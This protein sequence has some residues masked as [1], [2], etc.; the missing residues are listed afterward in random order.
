MNNEIL[1]NQYSMIIIKNIK[2]E[3]YEF[4]PITI[5]CKS[6]SKLLDVSIKLT[7]NGLKLDVSYTENNDVCYNDKDLFQKKFIFS[8]KRID[9][10][11]SEDYKFLKM[12]D[13]LISDTIE[14]YYI[15]YKEECSDEEIRQRK[16]NDL[17]I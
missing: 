10:P 5:H 6:Y 8:I 1:K 7:S 9:D 12:M 13:I 4:S 14:K 17:G 11:I 2:Y 3:I 15:F 16:L